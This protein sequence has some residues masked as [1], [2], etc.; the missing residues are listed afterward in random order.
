MPIKVSVDFAMGS[1]PL[2]AMRRAID[3]SVMNRQP[4]IITASPVWPVDEN[5]SS[6][7]AKLLP[8]R[9]EATG[10]YP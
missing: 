9:L 10:V 7:T 6:M 2:R 5:L 8:W 3:L 1:S 4:A